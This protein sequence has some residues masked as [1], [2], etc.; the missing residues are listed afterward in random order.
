MSQQHKCC[1]YLGDDLAS[2]G[3]GDG[4]P[5]SSKRHDVFETEFYKRSFQG[6]VDILSP[7]SIG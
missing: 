3:F 6:K 4:H 5:F 2:Y 1:V 7:K